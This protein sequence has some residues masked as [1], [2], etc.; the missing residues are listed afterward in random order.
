MTT[1]LN[2]MHIEQCFKVKQIREYYNNH[3]Y[4]WFPLPPFVFEGI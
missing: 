1:Y 3:L 4:P 2:A